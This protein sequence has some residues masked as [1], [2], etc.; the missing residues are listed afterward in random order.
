MST[1]VLLVQGTHA[2]GR[3]DP[4]AEWWHPESAFV[5]FLAQAGFSLVGAPRV[6]QWDTDLDGIGWL[7]RR[8]QKKHINWEAAGLNL[9]AY[10]VPPVTAAAQREDYVPI[11]DRNL[12]AHSHAAQVV[13]YACAA[14]LKIN[15]LLT[16]ASPVR[17]DMRAV[18][19]QA[20]PNIQSWRH[21]HSDDSDRIQWLGEVFDGKW[22]IVR[23]Q[24][25]ADVNVLLPDVSH[26][27]LLT[28]PAY[29][30]LWQVNGLVD[31][32]KGAGDA[33]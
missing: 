19:A 15:R 7:Q 24:P 18:Y 28:Q 3:T 29:F 13:A 30:P 22:G 2:W 31:F 25:Y 9:Y 17:E 33:D 10:L 11:A 14:G 27:K 21:V 32:L 5:A 16:L 8:P 6:F 20:R 1:P 23:R 4:R 26:S 12:I